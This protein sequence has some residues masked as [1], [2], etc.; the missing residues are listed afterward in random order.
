MEVLTEIDQWKTAA[1][2]QGYTTP[3]YWMKMAG[4]DGMTSR[5]IKLN[6]GS[7]TM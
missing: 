1:R 4:H 7:P 3:V 5:A 6:A 2:W